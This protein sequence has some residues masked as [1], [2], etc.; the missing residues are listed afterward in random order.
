M[1]HIYIC[2]QVPAIS[3]KHVWIRIAG[4]T[5]DFVS[6]G[7]GRRVL[8]FSLEAFFF[9]GAFVDGIL[10]IT[11]YAGFL[12][13]DLVFAVGKVEFRCHLF[14]ATFD[15]VNFCNLMLEEFSRSH[16]DYISVD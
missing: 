8:V 4:V 9:G 16:R 10:W 5:I 2:K 1:I 12:L 3:S 6:D 7:R 14:T 15:F 13:F 11:T